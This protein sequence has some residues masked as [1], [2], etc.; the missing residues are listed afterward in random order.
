MK[1]YVTR[2]IMMKYAAPVCVALLVLVSAIPGVAQDT[3][4]ITNGEWEPFLSEYSFHY[5]IASHIV[6]EA[7]KAEGITVEWRF[8]PWQRA[9]VLAQEGTDWD[10]S[11]CWWPSD[12]IRQDFLL[13]EPV[14]QSSTVFFHRSDDTFDWETLD[15]L[16]GLRV[17]STLGYDY[18]NAFTAAVESGKIALDE[19]PEDEQSWKKL[20]IGRIDILPNDPIVGYTQIR[21]IFPPED[22]KRLTHHPKVLQTETLNLIISKQSKNAEFFL[23]K[24]NAGLQKLQES[25]ML[26]QILNGVESGKYDKQD[27]KW[28][29]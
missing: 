4:R 27:T 23:Q 22:A 2:A 15:D 19:A 17:G 13:S 21:G 14:S 6:S 8:F 16:Q 25:G 29:E 5:G 9:F 3:I 28:T 26:E 11:C 18:G 1:K 24:F 7:F 10:A 20:L 12:D